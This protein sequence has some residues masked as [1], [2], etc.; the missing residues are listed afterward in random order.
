MKEALRILKTEL[1][2]GFTFI[3]AFNPLGQSGDSQ[4]LGCFDEGED[5]LMKSLGGEVNV[6]NE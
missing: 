6:A 4:V 3:G 5:H 2:A 1:S